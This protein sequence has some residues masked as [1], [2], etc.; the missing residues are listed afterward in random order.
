M[1]RRTGAPAPPGR[2]ATTI[3][4]GVIGGLVAGLG[5]GCALVTGTKGKTTTTKIMVGAA[6]SAGLCVITNFE[7]SGALSGIAASLVASSGRGGALRSRH[8]GDQSNTAAGVF[9]VDEG[10]LPAA[11]EAVRPRLVVVTNLFSDK[12]DGY[13]EVGVIAR[14]WKPALRGLAPDACVVLNADDP[15]VAYLGEDLGDDLRAK[16]VCFGLEDRRWARPGLARAAG[17]RR[18]ARCDLDLRYELSFYAHLGHYA[19]ER[20][21]WRRPAPRFAAWRVE[22]SETGGGR[23]QVSTPAGDRALALPLAGLRN[24]CNTLAAAAGASYILGSAS[25]ASTSSADSGLA[26]PTKIRRY[27]SP[28]STL[29]EAKPS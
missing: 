19:C 1:L 25:L 3:D 29:I 23:C 27:A 24:A 10:A 21:G 14:L 6:R 9:E 18:C 28:L 20:C 22:L 8:A 4:P 2:I 26:T 17:S 13:F 12:P 7:G 5:G 11:I 15:V 16:V